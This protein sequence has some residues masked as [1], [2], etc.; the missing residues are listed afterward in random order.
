MGNRFGRNQKRRMRK[1]ISDLQEAY[2][3]ECKLL[4]HMSYSLSVLKEEIDDAKRI[5][6]RN[7]I[8][9]KPSDVYV[10]DIYNHT[11]RYPRS[12]I[13]DYSLIADS[14]KI[15]SLTFRNVDLPVMAAS[16]DQDKFANNQHFMVRYGNRKYGYA[17]SE[18]ALKMMPKEQMIKTVSCAI[19]QSIFNE[20]EKNET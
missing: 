11:F 12:E 6:S 14:S 17:I 15:D 18:Q 10:N 16:V 13:F 7:S 8:A 1:E 19:A 5:L 3:R 4:E 20:L 2:V 9:F